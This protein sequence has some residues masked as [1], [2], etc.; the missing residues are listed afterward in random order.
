MFTK[1][2]LFLLAI[3]LL[4]HAQN[5]VKVEGI[6]IDE[7][8]KPI[9][10]VIITVQSS[11]SAA[12]TDSL[13]KFTLQLA[14]GSKILYFKL[15]GY[16]T[17]TVQ[18]KLIT[19]QDFNIT[20][21]L[22]RNLKL[23]AEVKVEDK[24]SRNQNMVRLNPALINQLPS[25]SGNFESI[26][27][28]LPGVSVNNELSS[29]YSVRGGNFDE[30]LI[31]INDIEIYKPFLIRNGQQEGLSLINPDLVNSVKFSAGGFSSRYGDKLSSVL[32]VQYKN[33][34][35]SR[36]QIG[37]GTNGVSATAFSLPGKLK[38]AFG[39]R[40]KQNKFIL[41]SQ[42]LVGS[43]DPQFYDFQSLLSYDINKK[44]TLQAL[45]VY[46]TSRFGIIPLSQTTEFGTLQQAF[47]LKVDYE[48][49]E[50]D[51][52]NNVVGALT[53]NYKPNH[54]LN[55]KWI[56]AAFFITEK[57]TFDIYGSYVFEEV[58][59]DFGGP[60]IGTIKTNRG[61]GA[62][63]NYGRNQ[64]EADVY[65]SEVR[66][67]Y[68]RKKM[69]WE[70]GFKAQKDVIND[71][72][73]EFSLADS[74]GFILPNNA[75]QFVLSES[76]EA[77]NQVSTTRLSGFLENNYEF[78]KF[79]LTSGLR[80]Y[81]NNFTN[82][83]IPSPRAILTFKPHANKDLIYR[84]AS[85][86]YTQQPF[87]REMRLFD[88]KVY[89]Q[90][91][92]QKSVHI[93]ASS[94]YK[95]RGL[96]TNLKFSVEAY[97]KILMDLVPYKIENLRIRYYANQLATGYATGLDMRINGEFIDGL[98]STFRLSLMKTAEDIVGDSRNI[99]DANGNISTIYPGYINRPTDQRINFS[100]FFQDRLLKSPTY[101]VHLNLLYGSGLPVG[102]PKAP[103]YQDVYK[104]PA[105]RRLDIGFSKN[106]LDPNARHQPRLFKKYLD[107]FII[108]AEV[109]NLLNINNTVSYLW[110]T[111][112]DNTQYA[113]PNFLTARQLN[114]R[115]IAKF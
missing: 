94:D 31:Y 97:Y 2:F 66:M 103:R 24:T 50:V 85:G 42:P 113:I 70:A 101:K 11:G 33:S 13:G 46:N 105:Y 29:Q 75:N 17:K 35:T 86:L 65:S 53:L 21:T 56:N 26:L 87:Y 108:Y 61:I 109:F 25:V 64:L 110:I 4:L 91:K 41:N 96:G 47:R 22:R 115:L 49:Q 36:F 14:P 18:V 34:D 76:V 99:K 1:I 79:N 57:E 100:A 30:N 23:L 73:K 93:V 71:K 5:R 72:V 62:Y 54:K 90:T 82:E 6:V 51:S 89:Q 7:N 16:T 27:K 114:V 48:G 60:N 102:P 107:S 83:F 68:S 38:Y 9:S 88:G 3:P 15:L 63:Q 104:I 74:A 80:A 58:N 55:F 19:G 45:G 32:D 84:L 8:L 98:E 81:Y 10:N 95:F 37:L 112:V 77:K 12:Q 67:L 78:G 52:Y 28:Q 111:D 43:Y 40:Q 39:F 20:T 44:V 59:N 92:S 69:L 106:I